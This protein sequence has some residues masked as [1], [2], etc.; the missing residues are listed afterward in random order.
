[1]HRH[2]DSSLQVEIALCV[3]KAYIRRRIAGESIHGASDGFREQTIVLG[4][5][6]VFSSSSATRCGAADESVTAIR[7]L[8]TACRTDADHCSAMLC[9]HKRHIFVF[10]VNGDQTFVI[11]YNIYVHLCSVEIGEMYAALVSEK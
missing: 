3:A 1:L 5:G 9:R 11:P 4:N 6:S 8:Y 2:R 7:G 10:A